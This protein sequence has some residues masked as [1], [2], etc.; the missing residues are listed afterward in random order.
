MRD[1]S[2]FLSSLN[3]K[4]TCFVIYGN[5]NWNKYGGPSHPLQ[6]NS[7]SAYCSLPAQSTTHSTMSSLGSAAAGMWSTCTVCCGPQWCSMWSACSW[8]SS[9]LLSSERTRIWWAQVQKSYPTPPKTVKKRVHLYIRSKSEWRV[10]G[11]SKNEDLKAVWVLR[12][13]KSFRTK[14]FLLYLWL[15]TR[16]FSILPTGHKQYIEQHKIPNIC[17]LTGV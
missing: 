3:I 11:N 13:I 8:E 5:N 12:D 9:L 17:F 15:Q 2:F 1:S 10:T 4:C 16:Y 7:S 6:L 14:A